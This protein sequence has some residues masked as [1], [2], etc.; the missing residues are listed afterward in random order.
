MRACSSTSRAAT[1]TAEPATCSERE[2]NVP[3]PRATSAVSE[4]STR[5]RSRGTP[6]VAEATWANAVSCPWPCGQTPTATAT[7]PSSAAATA[8]CSGRANVVIST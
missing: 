8:A 6:S 1:S 5:T 7:A 2:A 4:W 3:S